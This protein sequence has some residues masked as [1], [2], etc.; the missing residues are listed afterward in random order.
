MLHTV[1]LAKTLGS[2]PSGQCPSSPFF[3]GD[4]VGLAAI[5]RHGNGMK[6]DLSVPLL[7]GGLCILQQPPAWK[8]V[9]LPVIRTQI[10]PQHPQGLFPRGFLYFRSLHW[11]LVEY[12]CGRRCGM[13]P[14]SPGIA[15]LRCLPEQIQQEYFRH[16]ST[17]MS[18]SWRLQ[19]PPAEPGSLGSAFTIPKA[20][21]LR[22]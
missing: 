5:A 10:H 14:R 20:G 11:I 3:G 2:L 21:P 13:G 1:M 8:G 16:P 18:K 17:P 22:A 7:S 19:I 15:Q 6:E 9:A 12:R 4:A